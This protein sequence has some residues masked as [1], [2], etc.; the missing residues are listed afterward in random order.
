MD[1][2]FTE[3]NTVSIIMICVFTLTWLVF[4]LGM[5]K[6]SE[7]YVRFKEFKK[8]TEMNLSGLATNIKKMQVSITEMVHEQRRG[9]KLAAELIDQ[10]GNMTFEFEQEISEEDDDEE[11]IETE[12]ES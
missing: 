3:W 7:F 11:A 5:A 6:L 12:T 9:N 2:K 8:S 4:V 1:V 10:M